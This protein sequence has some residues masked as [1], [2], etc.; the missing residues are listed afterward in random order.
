[1][2]PYRTGRSRSDNE[3][4]C[5]WV[6]RDKRVQLAAVL[7][8]PRMPFRGMRWIAFRL[9]P[10]RTLFYNENLDHFMLR[11]GSLGN[12]LG[13]FLWRAKNFVRWQRRV[14]RTSLAVRAG[15][16]AGWL[17]IALKQ[18][19]PARAIRLDRTTLP[20]GIS[21]VIPSRNGRELLER[22]LPESPSRVDRLRLGSDCRG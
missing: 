22:L 21:V 15:Q 14:Q 10:L 18:L 20:A 19:L 3:A 6:L 12:I 2:D 9:A 1:V 13:H 11:P 4:Y 7:L 8:Q 16:A 5:R 17:A